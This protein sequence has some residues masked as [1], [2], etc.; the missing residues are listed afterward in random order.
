[1]SRKPFFRSFDGWWYAQIRV[2]T[3]RKQVKL[4][5]GKE[6]EQEAYRAFCRLLADHEGEAPKAEALT[7]A[8]VCD[9]FLDYSQKQHK[10][11]TYQLYRYYLQDF[12][13]THGRRMAVELKPFHVSR[14]LD[15]HP[16]WKGSR[17]N[18][19]ESVKRA[20]GW[21]EAE[22][23]LTKSPLKAVKKPAKGRR[24]RILSQEER[25][26]VLSAIKDQAFREFVLA[27][28]ETGCRPSEV[29]RVT[30][31][32]VN[33][34]AGLW[35]LKQHKTAKKTRRPRVVYLTPTMIELSRKLAEKNPDGSLF[36]S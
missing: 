26:T 11:E 7:V 33:L 24:D 22:G 35:V 31:A 29:S 16:T 12:C 32:D 23:L 19:I 21:A 28:Q 18:A 6:N 17:C 15:G 9:L 1:M 30:A 36:R 13:D 5:K 2:G 8:S 10:P 25:E 14:W 20:F 4:V 34:E 3:K 27:M